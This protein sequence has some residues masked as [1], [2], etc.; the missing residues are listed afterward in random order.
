MKTFQNWPD[1]YPDPSWFIHDRFG[2][3]I[4]FGLFSIGARHEWFMTTEEIAPETCR[5]TYFDQFNP[6]LFDAAVWA[7]TAKDC[8]VQYIVFTTKHHEGFALWDSEWTD[9][10]VTNTPFKRDLL[11][12]L[13]PAFRDVGIKIGL[14]HSLIDWYH[15]HF[16]ID[17]LHPQ[18]SDLAARESNSQR[19][20]LIYQD[21]IAGQVTEL[22]TQYGRIDYMWFDFPYSHRD[23]GW[24]KGKG[25]ED[26]DSSR[27]EKICRTLQP[28]M[29]INDRLELGRGITTPEQFQPE[30]PL[31]KDGL[32]VLW[33]AC[34]TMYGTWGYDRDALEWKSSDMLVKMLIDTV[35][36]GGNFLLNIG[37]NPR[38]EID[39]RAVKRMQAIGAWIRLHKEAI[40]D[41]GPSKYPVPKDCRYTQ[42]G[43]KLYLH[44]YSYPFKHIHLPE[45]ADQVRFIRFL[46]DGSEIFY[47]GFDPNEVITSTEAVIAPNDLVVTL[48][49]V[50]PN[51]L[52]PV[53]EITLK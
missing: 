37:P 35:S 1:H 4:H 45:I 8:G 48:P 42:N 17:G 50:P 28:D 51:V 52:I 30:K 3:F 14:Y 20:M 39:P 12:E 41:C 22:L 32:P 5:E 16:T 10:K 29:L 36:K 38:G 25:A 46:H 34:Q 43:K 26:W 49:V 23:W 24:S 19:D 13:L 11:A 27:L 47:R 53:L 31:E 15:P 2:L 21:F 44:V 18:R 7:Q 33:E 9:Y 40:I 6:N